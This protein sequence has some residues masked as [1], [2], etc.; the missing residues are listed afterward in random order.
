MDQAA[1]RIVKFTYHDYSLM[2]EDK[3][4]EL[5]EGDLL[6]AP[7][8]T[9]LHETV[10]MNIVRRLFDVLEKKIVGKIFLAPC[11]VVL[12]EEDVVQ[13]DIF[14]ISRAREGIITEK[15]I[16]GAPNLVV[17]IISPGTEERDRIVK[18][19][20][21]YKYGVQEYWIVDPKARTVEVMESGKKGLETIRVYP[22][23]ATLTSR[24][25]KGLSLKVR[26]LFV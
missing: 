10:R 21:Y 13:P 19:K 22:E 18:R 5:I 16:Q 25:L 6:M 9:I 15:N 23:N 4:H 2:P 3:R 12:S 17:E 20:L 14:F 24:C 7:A 26:S 11:D 1:Q 8:P